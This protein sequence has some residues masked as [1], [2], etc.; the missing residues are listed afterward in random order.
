MQILA[1]EPIRNVEDERSLLQ[2]L[3]EGEKKKTKSRI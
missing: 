2:R 3:E 1:F